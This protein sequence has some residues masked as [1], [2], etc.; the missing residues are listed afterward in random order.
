MFISL[1]STLVGRLVSLDGFSTRKKKE[2]GE[3]GREGA[4][5]VSCS[6]EKRIH[7]TVLAR[8]EGGYSTEG[9][10]VLRKKNNNWVIA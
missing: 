6:M 7:Y 5:F 10:K 8:R 1:F 3:K 9:K 4:H 2:E